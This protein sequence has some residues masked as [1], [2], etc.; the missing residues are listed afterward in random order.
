MDPSFEKEGATVS[1]HEQA[2]PKQTVLTLP[3]AVRVRT[4]DDGQGPV[5]LMLHG[6]PDNADEYRGLVERLRADF[7]C[8][9]PD[10][11]GYGRRDESFGLPERFDYSREHQITF[12]DDVL[13]ALKVEGPV[14]LVVHDVGGIMGVPWADKNRKRLRGVV[15]T[16]TVAF[17]K[18][19]WFGLANLFGARS[20]PGRL[21]ASINMS[22]I[23][24]WGGWVFRREFAKQN[25]QLDAAQIDRFVKDFALNQTALDTTLRHFR[26]ITRL[27]FFDGCD[28]MVKAISQ[29]VPTVAL[30]GEGDPYLT[31]TSLSKQMFARETTLL[32][33]IGHWVPILAAD[34]VAAAI[35]AMG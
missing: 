18:F 27:D 14:T 4:I 10:L 16:N 12:V 28:G 23:G 6:H 34:Q 11:P 20:S 15:Y 19:R 33:D 30:W 24:A 17:P 26:Q 3:S 5:V 2:A 21:L 13:A 35:R 9:A 32:P 7:R 31:D 1:T 8:I 29:A 25:P 22:L